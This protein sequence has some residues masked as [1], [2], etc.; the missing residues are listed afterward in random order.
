M[1]GKLFD[2]IVIY[3]EYI[4]LIY[5]RYYMIYNYE[6]GGGRGEYVVLYN[7]QTLSFLFVLIVRFLEKRGSL[8]GG[9]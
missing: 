3:N 8:G 2:I 1:E 9:K 5:H 4:I 7:Y 6:K